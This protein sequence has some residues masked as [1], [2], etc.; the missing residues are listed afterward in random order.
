MKYHA[1]ATLL[2]FGVAGAQ[3]NPAVL[4]DGT[5]TEAFRAAQRDRGEPV[6]LRRLPPLYP[7]SL[8]EKRI[9]GCT[10][11]QFE[12]DQEGLADKFVVLNSVP[13]GAFDR[14]AIDALFH[15]RFEP[16]EPPRR[17]LQ[18]FSFGFEKSTGTHVA[19]PAPR[20]CDVPSVRWSNSVS[21]VAL[22]HTHV[23]GP[24]FPPEAVQ[25]HTSG[26]VTVSYVVTV[27]GTPD[28]YRIDAAEPPG[29]F[30]KH[31][32]WALNQWRYE[33]LA[34]PTEAAVTF[35]F[36]RNQSVRG[37]LVFSKIVPTSTEKR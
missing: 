36:A 31:V 8:A 11:I 7:R 19:G 35:S 21:W 16:Q 4:N 12:I 13:P 25:A 1:A 10:V 2:A 3:A 23:V 9:A 37:L 28:L 18:S 17:A 32:L 30:D 27:D 24:T 5:T 33:P 26:C 6:I 20:G 29:V 34:V 15:W 14:A 22:K